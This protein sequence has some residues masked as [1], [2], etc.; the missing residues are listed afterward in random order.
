MTENDH[1]LKQAQHNLWPVVT[2]SMIIASP[3]VQ[4]NPW[5]MDSDYPMYDYAFDAPTRF[6]SISELTDFFIQGNWAL[7]QAVQYKNL[8]FIQQVNG[9][10]EWLTL[11]VYEG[12]LYAYESITMCGV[13]HCEGLAGYE[14]YIERMVN[15]TLDECKRFDY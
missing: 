12:K 2:R 15:A 5:L 14:N 13:I 1:S 4:G 6:D 7:R 10:D 8:V 9:G 3:S 11:K